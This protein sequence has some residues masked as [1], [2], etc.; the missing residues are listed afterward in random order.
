MKT[1]EMS[2]PGQESVQVLTGEALFLSM[3]GRLLYAPLEKE[4]LQTLLREEVFSETPF[5]WERPEIAAGMT[6]LQG[7]AQE[8]GET[9]SDEQFEL[10]K[11]DEVR[12]FIGT[13]SVIAPLWESSYFSE[14]RLLFQEQTLQVRAWYNRF[15]LQAEK[16][17]HEPDD[18]IGLELNFLSHLALQAVQSFENGQPED[19]S[20]YVKAQKEFLSQHLLYWGPAFC[21]QVVK[22]AHTR[23]YQGIAWLVF[24]SLVEL[25]SLFNLSTPLSLEQ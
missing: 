1:L 4:W 15:G 25:A 6:L 8:V 23:F 19:Y 3:L 2:N 22:Y 20:R 21:S 9:L 17:Y 12:L 11:G 7:W 16:L 14:E 13:P 24:G 5:G 18:H 10:L